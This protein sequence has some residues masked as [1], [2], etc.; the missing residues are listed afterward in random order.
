MAKKPF[1]LLEVI[2][3]GYFSHT[4]KSTELHERVSRQPDFEVNASLC[5]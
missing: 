4:H 3:Q 2:G 5:F 1:M